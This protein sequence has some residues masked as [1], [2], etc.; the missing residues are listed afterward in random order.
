MVKYAFDILGV[1][2]VVGV[3]NPSNK[4]SARVLEKAGLQFIKYD[5]FYQVNCAY[6]TLKR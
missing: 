2:K 5:R 6:Y 3:V 4:P 1:D